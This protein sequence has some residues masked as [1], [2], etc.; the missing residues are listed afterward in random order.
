[1]HKV[2]NFAQVVT[3]LA[4]WTRPNL[5]VRSP[6][7]KVYESNVIGFRVFIVLHD[8]IVNKLTVAKS[9]VVDSFWKELVEVEMVFDEEPNVACLELQS[10]VAQDFRMGEYVEVERAWNVA[11]LLFVPLEGANSDLESVHACTVVLKFLVAILDLVEWVHLVVV[12]DVE[13]WKLGVKSNKIGS[14]DWIQHEI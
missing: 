2:L 14:S 6:L 1:M 8:S 12:I 7:P 5:G 13:S 3:K 10:F 4:F 11:I 9:L